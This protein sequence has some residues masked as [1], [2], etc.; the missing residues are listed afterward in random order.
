M[1]IDE[2]VARMA[3]GAAGPGPPSRRLA[4]NTNP[5]PTPEGDTVKKTKIT[6][7]R[8]TLV[9]LHSIPNRIVLSG[10][11]LTSYNDGCGDGT[12]LGRTCWS[13]GQTC[14]CWPNCNGTTTCQ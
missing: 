13:C 5:G 6:L 7:S 4:S 9:N 2:L 11:G 12:V 14:S 10:D 1:D 3:S 8:E